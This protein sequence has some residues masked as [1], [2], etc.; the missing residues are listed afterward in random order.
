MIIFEVFHSYL[1]PCPF[2]LHCLA[3][4]FRIYRAGLSD[5]FQY[6]SSNRG[7]GMFHCNFMFSSKFPIQMLIFYFSEAAIGRLQ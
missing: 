7:L 5:R 6:V 1:L 2:D 3:V 4:T